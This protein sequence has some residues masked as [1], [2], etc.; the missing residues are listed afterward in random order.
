MN[1][2][3]KRVPLKYILFIWV[4]PIPKMPNQKIYWCM[5]WN[6]EPCQKRLYHAK[7][8]YSDIISFCYVYYTQ[9]IIPKKKQ[10]QMWNTHINSKS[11]SYVV[12]TNL[13]HV[14]KNDP[15]Q[16]NKVWWEFLLGAF[17][18]FSIPSFDVFRPF[19][20]VFT[21]YIYTLYPK[22]E[23]IQLKLASDIYI[24]TVE[25][26]PSTYLF[27]HLH[28]KMGLKREDDKGFTYLIYT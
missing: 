2:G 11:R 9:C 21:P 4:A 1:I 22:C 13:A 6:S 5:N 27:T 12:Y 17:F 10:Y 16:K 26:T 20:T 8:I 19:D 24:N 3:Q 15:T 23:H 28:W 7:S 14:C 18:P 25:K